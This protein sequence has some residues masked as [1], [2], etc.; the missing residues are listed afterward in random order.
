MSYVVEHNQPFMTLG[1]VSLFFFIA[2][3]EQP[4]TMNCRI[5]LSPAVATKGIQK[6]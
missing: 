1:F 4:L 5:C 3:I 2:N 6:S